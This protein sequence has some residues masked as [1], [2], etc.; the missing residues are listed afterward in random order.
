MNNRIIRFIDDGERTPKKPYIEVETGAD[1]S[2]VSFADMRGDKLA[3]AMPAPDNDALARALAR[4]EENTNVDH[5]II[6]IINGIPLADVD[7]I[8]IALENPKLILDT[9]KEQDP[10]SIENLAYCVK[11]LAE[12]NLATSAD[13]ISLMIDHMSSIVAVWKQASANMTNDEN[14]AVKTQLQALINQLQAL[15]NQHYGIS[16]DKPVVLEPETSV[17]KRLDKYVPVQFKPVDGVG[18]NRLFASRQGSLAALQRTIN[19]DLDSAT[20]DDNSQALITMK[21]V[22]RDNDKLATDLVAAILADTR[23]LGKFGSFDDNGLG[24]EMDIEQAIKDIPTYDEYP[25]SEKTKLLIHA[26]PIIM[27]ILESNHNSMTELA[28]VLMAL[29]AMAKESKLS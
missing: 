11:A 1:L 12:G 7:N 5:L 19:L 25:E 3:D 20:I 6:K 15:I 23:L 14:Q 29:R 22:Y 21:D 2:G 16:A 17:E 4:Q 10:D 18:A 27:A 8:K 9:Y 24:K 28:E 26:K 13:I